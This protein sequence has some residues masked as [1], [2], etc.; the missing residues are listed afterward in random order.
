MRPLPRSPW[1]AALLAAALLAV[2]PLALGQSE[3]DDE[4]GLISLRFKGGTATEYVNAIRLEGPPANMHVDTAVEQVRMPP[5][6]LNRVSVR[7]ALELL[8]GRIEQRPRDQIKIAVRPLTR[9]PHEIETYHVR[10][11]LIGMSR[12]TEAGVWSIAGLVEHG[13]PAEAILSAIET[14]V[15]VVNSPTDSVVRFHK[16]T[17]LVIA[18]GDGEQLST[19]H[20]VIDRLESAANPRNAKAEAAIKK[21]A[22]IRMEMERQ[23]VRLEELER[24]LQRKEH[25]LA[26]TQ[27]EL[28]NLQAVLDTK[29]RRSEP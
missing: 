4:S 22:G 16:D 20:Q 13:I 11:L 27:A 6:E 19:I 10:A 18:R 8:D 14:A 12:Q 23:A 1:T 3:R 21:A 9:S 24:T 7:T 29:R 17:G 5:V 2:P 26:E 28:Q 25:E 15:E